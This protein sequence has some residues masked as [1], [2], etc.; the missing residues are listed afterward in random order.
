MLSHKVPRK[1]VH[2]VQEKGIFSCCSAG[3][4]HVLLAGEP[5]KRIDHFPTVDFFAA[6]AVHLKWPQGVEYFD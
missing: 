3:Q 6:P 5:A 4:K 1:H 2:F